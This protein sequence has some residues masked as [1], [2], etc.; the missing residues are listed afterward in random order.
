[1]LHAGLSVL[2]IS[3]EYVQTTSVLDV[4]CWRCFHAVSL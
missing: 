4:L 2:L 3:Q 1:L